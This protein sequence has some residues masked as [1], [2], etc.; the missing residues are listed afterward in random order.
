[1]GVLQGEGVDPAL[2]AD[3]AVDG[4]VG[5][6]AGVERGE[7]VAGEVPG[8]RVSAARISAFG[9]GTNRA[10]SRSVGIWFHYS[11]ATGRRSDHLW[12]VGSDPTY[13]YRNCFNMTDSAP[14]LR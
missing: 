9:P 13:G 12:K 4:Y 11:C 3:A 10:R 6:G 8:N 7:H 5:R 14:L 2:A 1:M